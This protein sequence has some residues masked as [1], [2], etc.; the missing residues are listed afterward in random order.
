MIDLRRQDRQE[1]AVN[2]LLGCLINWSVLWGVYGQPVTA[3]WVMAA[4]IVLTW[5]RSYSIRRFFRWREAL[6]E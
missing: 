5:V 4:M 6:D 2:V 3:T 1:A